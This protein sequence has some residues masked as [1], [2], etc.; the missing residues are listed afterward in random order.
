MCLIS[1]LFFSF[2]L[3]VPIPHHQNPFDEGE[4]EDQNKRRP[5][6]TATSPFNSTDLI[7][8]LYLI[9]QSLE[10]KKKN[11]WKETPHT[12]ELD[13]QGYIRKTCHAD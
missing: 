8:S 4:R 13:R 7:F 2:L 1:F 5:E 9:D 10:K 11:E 12:R 6:Q 3:S